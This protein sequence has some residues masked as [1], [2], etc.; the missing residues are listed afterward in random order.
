MQ[1]RVDRQTVRLE[2]G[3]ITLSVNSDF[4]YRNQLP[5]ENS[6]V[7]PM[8]LKTE[9]RLAGQH[10][11]LIMITT[12]VQDDTKKTTQLFRSANIG[13]LTL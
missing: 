2:S 9:W 4:K 12:H 10:V 6:N 7:V 3:Y 8:F 11:V 1:F 13:S 5:L